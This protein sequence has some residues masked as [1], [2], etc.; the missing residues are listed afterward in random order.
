MDAEMTTEVRSPPESCISHLWLRSASPSVPLSSPQTAYDMLVAL[1][2][3][4]AKRCHSPS[5]PSSC[6]L[7]L[8]AD[9]PVWCGSVSLALYIARLSM[10]PVRPALSCDILSQADEPVWCVRRV[11]AFDRLGYQAQGQ[12]GTQTRGLAHP[13]G[14][15]FGYPQ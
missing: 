10:L 5:P 7:L 15:I 14:H 12:A 2:S 13:G 11:P 1:V 9:E 4:W 3:T 8:Q 6:A